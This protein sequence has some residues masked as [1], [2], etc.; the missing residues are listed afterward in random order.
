MH[1][2]QLL[3]RLLASAI[4]LFI[5]SLSAPNSVQASSNDAVKITIHK[6]ASDPN[7]VGDSQSVHPVAGVQYDLTRVVAA[8]SQ[9]IDPLDPSTYTPASGADYFQ[10]I[11]TTNADGDAVAD[12]SIGLV[13]GSY[14]IKELNVPKPMKPLVVT[15]PYTVEGKVYSSVTIDPKS[16]VVTTPSPKPTTPATQPP[17]QIAQMSGEIKQ[18]N[19]A[20]IMIMSVFLIIASGALYYR[21]G[22]MTA[23]K[24]GGDK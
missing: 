9:S 19:Y 10:Q 2:R 17:A 4:F 20:S 6:V 11:I 22:L 7:H 1:K 5:G 18:I 12:A 8:E 15:L 13:A 16:G 14:L 23:R 24:G 3:L 21:R